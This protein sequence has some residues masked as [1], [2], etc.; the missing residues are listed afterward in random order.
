MIDVRTGQAP[1]KLTRDEFHDRFV[2][3][4]YDPAFRVEGDAI[5]GWDSCRRDT[6]PCS[7]ATSATTHPTSTTIKHST[8][9]P[10]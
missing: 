8:R 6:W 2:V 10:Q 5:V 9:T 1:E 7:T 4:F 3:R